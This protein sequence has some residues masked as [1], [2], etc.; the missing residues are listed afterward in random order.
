MLTIA[1]AVADALDLSDAQVTDLSQ[2]APF[3]MALPFE[4]SS[5]GTLH[6]YSKEVG[7][8]VVGFRDEYEGRDFGKSQDE[9][10]TV[11][12]KI[13]DFSWAIARAAAKR[14]RRGEA[15]AIAREG[16]RHLRA[17]LFVAEQQFLNGL[18]G[19]QA[20]G[21]KGLADNLLLADT[22]HVINAGG[23]TVDSGSSVYLVTLG[24]DAV[25]GVMIEDSPFDLGETVVQNFHDAQG[26]NYPAYYTPGETH[27]GM[28]VGG[29][30][31]VVRICNLTKQ[32]G[33]GLTDDLIFQALSMF[34]GMRMP[35]HIVAGRESLEQLR[36]SRTPITRSQ[37]GTAP[38]MPRDVDGI[39]IIKT[40]ALRAT[41]AIL[42]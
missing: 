39:P 33:K 9:K 5:N 27:L 2:S 22:D 15:D 37:Q 38:P 8:P 6:S 1:D 26:K 30:H 36:R 12:L 35:T 4:P 11:A 25:S 16:L 32:S 31:D 10:V 19:G 41:E 17:A 24:E 13:L 28:Q 34:P 20:Q 23:S 42:A 29:A 7:A 18:V 3:L 21:F 40:E 14:W